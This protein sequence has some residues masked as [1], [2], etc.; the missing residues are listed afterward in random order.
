[1]VLAV[2]QQSAVDGREA[3]SEAVDSWSYLGGFLLGV[4]Q[5]VDFG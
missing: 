3:P 5:C 2:G 1:M 4:V